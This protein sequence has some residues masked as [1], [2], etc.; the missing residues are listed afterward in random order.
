MDSLNIKN[1]DRN[2]SKTFEDEVLDQLKKQNKLLSNI[3]IYMALS[4]WLIFGTIAWGLS[5]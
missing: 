2:S 5:Q 3:H 4:F 1:Q